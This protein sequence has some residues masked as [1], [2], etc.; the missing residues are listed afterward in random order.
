MV[1]KPGPG[2]K[3]PVVYRLADASLDGTLEA[4]PDEA[5]RGPRTPVEAVRMVL[6]S[7]PG[8]ALPHGHGQLRRPGVL[9][10]RR[11]QVAHRRPLRPARGPGAG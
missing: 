3:E 8:Q 10:P 7:T 1:A 5:A 6:I 2:R 9:R 11:A 4:W